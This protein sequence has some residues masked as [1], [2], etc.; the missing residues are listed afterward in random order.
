[1]IVFV[2]V[3]VGEQLPSTGNDIRQRDNQRLAANGVLTHTIDSTLS[4]STLFRENKNN[5]DD[6]SLHYG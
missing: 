2:S 1:M 6:L 3:A 5:L 4:Q